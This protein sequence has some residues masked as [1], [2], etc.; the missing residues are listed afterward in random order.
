MEQFRYFKDS[1]DFPNTS[2]VAILENDIKSKTSLF[3][4]LASEFKFPS[5]FGFNWD[6]L[7]DMLIDFHWVNNNEIIL[8]HKKI[9][10]LPF[11]ELKIY[12]EVLKDVHEVWQQSDSKTFI[13]LFPKH[14][15]TRVESIIEV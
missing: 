12:L 7:Y 4:K 5:Y 8:M 2:Y 13:V 14:D 11:Y 10:E 9:P 3:Q 15:Q 1:L 6:A